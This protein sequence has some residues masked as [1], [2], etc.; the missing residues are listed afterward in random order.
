MTTAHAREQQEMP[1]GQEILRAARYYVSGRRGLIALAVVISLAG[2]A[3]NWSWLVA[4]GIAPILIAALPCAA[5]CALGL[6]MARGSGSTCAAESGQTSE[7]PQSAAANDDSSNVVRASRA[8]D[9]PAAESAGQET[10][11][12]PAGERIAASEPDAA[13]HS[14]P[15]QKRS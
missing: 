7:P 5:M 4:V 10:A 9:A 15:V 8:I 6:C 2:L 13:S 12:D 14:N 1:L 3:F 11:E